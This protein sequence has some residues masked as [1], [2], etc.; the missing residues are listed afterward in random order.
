VPGRRAEQFN[1]YAAQ[2]VEL[3]FVVGEATQERRSL[4][5]EQRI[6][7]GQRSIERFR[8]GLSAIRL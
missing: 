5:S 8:K 2:R 3:S 4:A 1:E 7:L 6:T